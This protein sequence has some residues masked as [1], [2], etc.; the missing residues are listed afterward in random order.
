[1]FYKLGDNHQ[2][3]LQIL[4]QCLKVTCER[5]DFYKARSAKVKRLHRCFQNVSLVV[6]ELL[7]HFWMAAFDTEM[8][9]Y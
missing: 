7:K 2:I 5:V 8:Y 1:M 4:A 3:L 6:A 9:N